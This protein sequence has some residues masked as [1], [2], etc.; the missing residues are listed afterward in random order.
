MVRR[1]GVNRREV[2]HLGVAGFAAVT[3]GGNVTKVTGPSKEDPFAALD[4]TAMADL[5]RRKEAKPVELVE[6]AIG[7]IERLNPRVNAVCDTFF[8][9]ALERARG[10]LADGPFRG[11]PFLLKDLIAYEGEELTY[12]SRFFRENVARETDVLVRR[13]EAAGLVMLGKT[14]TCEFGLL[15]TTEPALHGPTRNPWSLEH[16]A[17]GSSGGAA[18]A[19]AAGMVPMAHASDGGGS[20][21]IPAAC[22]GLF[23]LK[24]SRGRN[25]E[26]PDPRWHGLSVEHCVSRSVRDSA[27]L[28][29]ATLGPA[30]GDRWWCPAPKR[31]FEEEVGADPGS[32]RIAFTTT[33]FTGKKA[34]ADCVAAVDS[35]AKLLEE[36]GHHVEEAAPEIDGRAFGDAFLLLWAA[37]PGAV[38]TMASKR[39]G[40][41]PPR[42]AFEP[43]TWGLAGLDARHHPSDLSLAYG[44]MDRVG[45]TMADFHERYDVLLTPVLGAPPVQIGEIDQEKPFEEVRSQLLDYVAFTPMFNVTGAPAMSVPLHRNEAGLPIGCHF[46]APY[47]GEATLLRLAAQLEAARPW[48]G[49]R[50]PVSAI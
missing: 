24:P 44:V 1:E 40:H 48:A 47:A 36:L 38:L 41:P 20:I 25:A 29:D 39:L 4:A 15:P 50:P 21:R 10:P 17:G 13:M 32:L 2:L 5:V 9:R 35:A 14:N 12:G 3:V 6:A 7:R 43:F 22:C 34:H 28:L 27:R 18:A 42:E 49:R 23:G 8:T 37:I 46:V 33:S 45:Y 16:S 26:R 30:P 11:V 19:V 31:P